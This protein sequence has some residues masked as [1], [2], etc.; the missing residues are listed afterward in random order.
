MLNTLKEQDFQETFK[1][2]YDAQFQKVKD[3]YMQQPYANN[4]NTGVYIRIS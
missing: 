3:Y 4:S 1:N 2:E